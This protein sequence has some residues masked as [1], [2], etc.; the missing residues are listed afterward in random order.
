MSEKN[1]ILTIKD[2]KETQ[3][4]HIPRNAVAVCVD[5]PDVIP[6]VTA[7]TVKRGRPAKVEPAK[8]G[9]PAKVEVEEAPHRGRPKGSGKKVVDGFA[10][11]RRSG[12]GK[13]EVEKAPRRSRRTTVEMGDIDAPATEKPPQ[14]RRGPGRPKGS[15]K[16]AA[17]TAE[18]KRRGRKPKMVVDDEPEDVVITD[19]DD[20][21]AD[22]DGVWSDDDEAPADPDDAE[23]PADSDDAE[24]DPDDWGSV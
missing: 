23:A 11:P 14:V 17:D 15:G 3:M 20:A 8:R 10:P 1:G 13:V 19:D 24:E 5:R 7:G 9:R 12:K 2:L 18:P 22:V 21:D 16:K 6:T 4:W